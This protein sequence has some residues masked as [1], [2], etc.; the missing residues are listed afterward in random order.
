MLLLRNSVKTRQITRKSSQK[1]SYW[2]LIEQ[3]VGVCAPAVGTFQ[4]RH[5]H[6]LVILCTAG[7]SAF[8]DWR[9]L[10]GPESPGENGRSV[11]VLWTFLSYFISSVGEISWETWECWKYYFNIWMCAGFCSSLTY[12]LG[13]YMRLEPLVGQHLWK[14]QLFAVGVVKWFLLDIERDG[15]KCQHFLKFQLRQHHPADKRCIDCISCMDILLWK[16]KTANVS[17]CRL[18]VYNAVKITLVHFL[19]YLKSSK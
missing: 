18:R 6:L 14:N 3:T 10:I 15:W 4:M 7:A 5:W 9:L 2:S 16:S 19:I 12:S 11:L 17:I 8:T 13:F 1:S